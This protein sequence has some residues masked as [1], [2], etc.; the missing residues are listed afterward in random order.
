M[1]RG[2]YTAASGLTTGER[3]QDMLA[4]N[5]ANANTNGYKAQDGLVQAFPQV[6]QYELN[7]SSAAGAN[8]FAPAIGTLGQGAFLQEMVPRFTQGNLQSS[9]N[10]YAFA[11]VDTAPDALLNPTG[12]PGQGVQSVERSFFAVTDLAG[13]TSF[14]RDGNFSLGDDGFLKTGT[15]GYVLAVDNNGQPIANSRIGADPATQQPVAYVLDPATNQ[16]APAANL[17]VNA[18]FGIATVSNAEQLMDQGNGVYSLGSAQLVAIGQALP[19]SPNV[20]AAPAGEV[21]NRMIETSNVDPAQTMTQ[22]ITVMRAYEANTKVIKT[23]DETLQHAVN[24]VGRV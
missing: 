6:M 7:G 16:Y 4:N 17:G 24:D 14:T 15:G 2:L 19:A 1:I 3:L 20:I 12:A 21:R 5:L 8:A 13:N 10:P 9:S 23:L 18:S 22:M 11:I